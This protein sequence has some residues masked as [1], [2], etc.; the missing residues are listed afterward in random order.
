[1]RYDNLRIVPLAIV[2]SSLYFPSSLV[3][4]DAKVTISPVCKSLE[5]F[6]INIQA[7]GFAPDSSVSWIMLDKNNTQLSNGY[8]ATDNTGSFNENTHIE[9]NNLNNYRFIFFD[10]SNT[11]YQRDING[12]VY[13]EFL[14]NPC[15]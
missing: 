9:D 14:S 5:G 11:N 12:S 13:E 2:L 15:K 8:F 7:S 6:G 1:M 3:F 4:A 10:D